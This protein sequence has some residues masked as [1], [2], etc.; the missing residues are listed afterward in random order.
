LKQLAHK[1]KGVFYDHPKNE[2]L[3]F[4]DDGKYVGN[5]NA[6][7]EWATMTHHW[8]IVFS[9][10]MDELR[11]NA[12]RALSQAINDNPKSKFVYMNIASEGVTEKVVFELFNH[13]APKACHNF[14]SLCQ[15][16]KREADNEEITYVD[17]EIH[18]IVPDMFIQGGKVKAMGCASVFGAEFED[19]SFHVKHTEKGLLGMC[20]REGFAHTNESM[21]YITTGAPLSFLDNKNVCFGRVI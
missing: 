13:L 17:T 1:L 16:F 5:C 4:L 18:R 20:R 11:D 2:A 19:E 15:G 7:A 21:F 6:F 3:I 8:N 9:S 14:M 10:G 12:V